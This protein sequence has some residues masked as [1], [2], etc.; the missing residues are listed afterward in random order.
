MVCKQVLR[1]RTLP[2]NDKQSHTCVF[3]YGTAS[4][5]AW[6]P[7]IHDKP[8]VENDLTENCRAGRDVAQWLSHETDTADLGGSRLFGGAASP[9][10]VRRQKRTDR[11]EETSRST[12][13]SSNSNKRRRATRS[14]CWCRPA[15]TSRC[16]PRSCAPRASKFG[17]RCSESG[18]F[19]I[20]ISANDLLWLEGLDGVD[21]ISVDAAVYL[22][23]ALSAESLLSN[24][25]G[26]GTVKKAS[27]LR[28]LLGLSDTDP[29]GNGIGVA[30]VD[31]GIAPVDD[32]VANIK[33]FY[34]F[35]NG[36]AWRCRP[37]PRDGCG[38]GTHV[39]G[40]VAGSGGRSNGQYAGVAPRARLIGLRVLDNSGSGSTSDVIAALQFATANKATLGIDVINLS[41]GHPAFESAATDPLVQ[42]V[43]AASR[44]GIV[45]VVSAGNV[46]V[47]PKTN[48]IGCTVASSSQEMHHRR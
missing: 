14:T 44:A 1:A 2:L 10:N 23:A 20:D 16:W 45:V 46:G 11:N 7:G 18:T 3:R 30:I 12:W 29:M 8:H 22:S 15:A 26:S 4:V 6:D 40:L 39:A 47:N 32:L 19:A 31:S 25:G 28:A 5:R 41:L 9:G 24:G 33:A 17:D 27:D 48:T 35:T 38:H 43:E 42:A 36:R 21:S 34:D 37:L 13:R